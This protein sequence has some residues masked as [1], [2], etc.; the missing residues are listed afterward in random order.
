MAQI[1][2]EEIKN[3]ILENALESFVENGY[4]K[5]SMKSI[6][7][8]SGIAVGNIYNYFKDKE[9]L[10]DTIAI[11]V[12]NEI[13]EIF[14]DTIKKPIKLNVDEKSRKFINIYNSNKKIFVMVLENSNNTKFESLKD[15][16]I[17]NFSSVIIRTKNKI[18]K[19][20]ATEKEKVFVKAFTGAYINGI[21]SILMQKIDEDTK[22]EVL[23]DFLSFM[24]KALIS[25]F[26]F[27]GEETT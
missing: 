25:K 20:T 2:K 15:K 18:A 9:T 5:T 10:Y 11:P 13:N 6:A 24:K 26:N 7:Q 16:V 23:Y 19:K 21:I 14:T 4:K 27:A 12:F 3:K 22:L 1:L 17:E 8:N